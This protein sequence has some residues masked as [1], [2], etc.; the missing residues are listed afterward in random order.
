MNRYFFMRP[1]LTRL[2]SAG[3]LHRLVSLTLRVTASLVILFSMVAFFKVGR[4]IFGLPPTGIP[5]GIFFQLC[6]LLAI[7][8]VVHAMLLRA[9]DIDNLDKEA[10][11]IFPVLTLL[12]KLVGEVVAFFIALIAIGG[13]VYVWFTGKSVATVM[14]PMAQ[15][16]PAFGE[17]TFMGGIEFMVGGVLAAI[18]ILIVMYA[19]SETIGILSR[20][21]ES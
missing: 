7:Y 13:G 9:R 11:S 6:F 20:L 1:L 10:Y 21:E 4:V 18:V 2:E 17:A 16:L 8:C 15:F 14:N 19:L 12:L 3:F 5:G